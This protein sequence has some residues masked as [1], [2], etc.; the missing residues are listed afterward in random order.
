MIS[1]FKAPRNANWP[2]RLAHP[3][4]ATPTTRPLRERRLA[5]IAACLCALWLATALP[6]AQAQVSTADSPAYGIAQ[7]LQKESTDALDYSRILES[8]GNS[9]QARF[10]RDIAH[11]RSFQAKREYAQVTSS[12]TFNHTAVAAEALFQ[13]A[14]LQEHIDRQNYAAVQTL[15]QLRNNYGDVS[16]PDKQAALTAFHRVASAVDFHSKTTFPDVICYKI[17]DFFVA[18]TGGKSYSYWIA[19]LLFSA[20]V[21]LL[22]TP[23]SNKQ[24]AS[25][26]E[27]QKLQPHIKEVQAKYKDNPQKTQEAVMQIYREHGVNPAGGCLP[28]LVQIPIMIGL[29]YT[30]R[31]YEF[32]FSKGTFLW[33]GSPLSHMFPQYLAVDLSQSDIPLLILYAI[34]MYIQQRMTVPAD[35]QQAEQQR[36]MAIYTP[37]LSTYFFL[38]YKLPAAFVLYYL[39]FNVLSMLQQKYYMKKRQGD[40]LVTSTPSGKAP[41]WTAESLRKNGTGGKAALNGNQSSERGK[42]ESVRSDGGSPKSS[43]GLKPASRG[44][45]SPKVHPKK[46]RR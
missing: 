44:A 40:D 39:I 11:G 3:R 32:Q 15:K 18:L 20:I 21:K 5:W 12:R 38:Q 17:M 19:I 16:Y 22:M 43:N 4:C 2:V 33:I 27:M 36:M 1:L 37:F 6:P 25:M 14:W 10:E 9:T 30:I 23:L 7:R 24:Y 34:S 41:T 13:T 45:I 31:V 26:K 8:E 42:I 29:Y 46:K 35:P 28:L